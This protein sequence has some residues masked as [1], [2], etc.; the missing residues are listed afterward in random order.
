MKRIGNLVPRIADI[1]N[2]LLAFQKA[3]RGKR[4]NRDALQFQNCLEENLAL[5][6]EEILSGNV[7]VGQ[8]EY[9]YIK[10]PKQRLICAASFRE[11]VLHQAIMNICHPYFERNLIDTSYATR[12]EKGIYKAINRAKAAMKRYH[13]VA[14]FD[15]RKYFDSISHDLLKRK[16]EKMYKDRVL[17]NILSTII[18]SYSKSEN[19][20]IPIGNLTSQYFANYYLSEMDHWIKEELRVPEYLRYMDDFLIF[21]NKRYELE[22][23]TNQIKRFSER[24]LLLKLKPIIVSNPEEGI[25]FLGY[26]IFANKIRLTQRSKRRFVRKYNYYESMLEKGEWD[27]KEYYEHIT[28]LLSY[29]LKGYTMRL[30]RKVLRYEQEAQ[31]ACCAVAAGTTTRRTAELRIGTTI[32]PTT[33]T[34]TTASG[35]FSISLV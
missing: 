23:Y 30:R 18:E 31:T 3:I 24:E 9:F 27:E 4:W 29:V 15:F 8:Y 19:K 12:P 34:P 10:D 7:M 26:R 28:P 13:Y 33:A 35:L 2:L 6:R 25:D 5:L 1:D 11:R 32:L 17:L 14:K 16:L 21:S 20:G 22:F